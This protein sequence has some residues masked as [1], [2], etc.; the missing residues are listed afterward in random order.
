[1]LTPAEW[2][3]LFFIRKGLRN[4]DIAKRRSTGVDAV[5]YHVSNMLAKLG[6]SSREEL[7]RWAGRPAL[8]L[9]YEQGEPPMQFLQQVPLFYVE[10]V[11]R[12]V[13]FYRDALGM[14]IVKPD[15][16][17]TDTAV[18][19]LANG[20]AQLVI[21]E[22]GWHDEPQRGGQQ[23]GERGAVERR[24]H[25]EEAKDAVLMLYV[26]SCADAYRELQQRGYF[27]AQLEDEQTG[28]SFYL[29]DPDGNEVRV[30]DMQSYAMDF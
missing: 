4:R 16:L 15:E 10:D 23:R 24:R 29:S 22:A 5:K 14:T 17:G 7:G 8:P 19:S 9:Q 20:S 26:D 28:S 6:L 3:V 12:S 18:V 25:R 11:A 30:A 2:Q 1:V 13:A 27:D 21:H